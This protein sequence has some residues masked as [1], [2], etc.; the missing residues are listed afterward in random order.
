MCIRDRSYSKDRKARKLME[1]LLSKVPEA[2]LSGSYQQ[3][4]ANPWFENFDWDKLIDRELKAPYIPP[5]EKYV[6]DG[7]IENLESFNK[8][9]SDEVE[10]DL[11]EN[12]HFKKEVSRN[13]ETNWDKDF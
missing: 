4:K 3:L 6:S 1:Q 13:V 8:T 11:N 9:V 12:E 10:N 2:R 5:K 7:E